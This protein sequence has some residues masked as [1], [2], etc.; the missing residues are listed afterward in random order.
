MQKTYCDQCKKEIKQDAKDF[1]VSI[2]SF[3]VEIGQV[4]TGT[5]ERSVPETDVCLPCLIKAINK[6]AS[7][8]LKRPY[9]KKV[10]EN[11]GS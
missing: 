1:R 8:V 9:H 4:A 11:A 6:E 5:G 10:V 7:R 3:I 2:G